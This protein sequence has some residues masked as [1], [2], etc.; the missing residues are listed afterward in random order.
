MVT[1]YIKRGQIMG[2][3]GDKLIY[4]KPLVVEEAPQVE[5]LP[6]EEDDYEAS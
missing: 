6:E 4:K 5:D 3:E 1:E 2:Y